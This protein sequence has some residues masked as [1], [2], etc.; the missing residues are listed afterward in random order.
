MDDGGINENYKGGGIL[1]EED[2]QNQLQAAMSVLNEDSRIENK[3]RT[4]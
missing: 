4:A 1:D 2:G 3:R